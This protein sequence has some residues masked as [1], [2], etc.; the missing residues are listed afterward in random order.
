MGD[1]RHG[2]VSTI[3]NVFCKKGQEYF[4]FMSAAPFFL[5]YISPF[6]DITLLQNWWK[7]GQFWWQISKNKSILKKTVSYFWSMYFI[8]KTYFSIYYHNNVIS[9]KKKHEHVFFN[10]SFRIN[11]LWHL[12]TPSQTWWKNLLVSTVT[13]Q[14]L[15]FLE[16]PCANT[17]ALYRR[18]HGDI[19][20]VFAFDIHVQLDAKP[21]RLSCL[22][23]KNRKLFKVVY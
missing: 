14:R 19:P 22:S 11:K 10:F 12:C 17:Q 18:A 9:S 13:F 7:V 20:E 21:L 6:D 23:K 8:K 16:D 5:A 3:N 2:C 15:A 4:S 1:G